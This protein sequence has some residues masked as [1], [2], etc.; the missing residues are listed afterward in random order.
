MGYNYSSRDDEMVRD[1]MHRAS[2]PTGGY[3]LYIIIV[4]FPIGQVIAK[5]DP[6]R[7][8]RH[9]YIPHNMNM[10]HGF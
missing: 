4:C 5:G 10:L 1:E 2:S 9:S 6:R 3:I 7:Y 8:T